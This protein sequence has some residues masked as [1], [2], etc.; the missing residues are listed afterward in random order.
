[1]ALRGAALLHPFDTYWS[2]KLEETERRRDREGET[3]RGRDRER[4]I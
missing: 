4:E 3:E 2:D 1:V